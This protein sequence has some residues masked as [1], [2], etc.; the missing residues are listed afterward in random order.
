MI[1][2]QAVATA[3]NRFEAQI[4]LQLLGEYRLPNEDKEDD[5]NENE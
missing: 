5:G 2:M 1:H 3:Q 4:E